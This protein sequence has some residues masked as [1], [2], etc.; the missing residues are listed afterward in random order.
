[1]KSLMKNN[2]A[3][4]DSFQ[5]RLYVTV[6]TEM[7]A[8][9]HWKKK[10]PP[11]FSSVIEGIPKILRPV[12]DAYNI[13]PI[14][15]VSP[16][17]VESGECCEVLK[18]EAAKGA[19]IGA[20]L[21]P[22]YIG[23]CRQR[24]AKDITEQFPCIGYSREI[25]KAKISSLSILI[26]ERLGVQ[27]EWYRAARFGTDADTIA[28]L[29]ELGFKYDSSFT[30]H[31]DWTKKG[32]P[33]HKPAPLH[34]YY[35]DC[36]HIYKDYGM[37]KGIKEYPVTIT[38]KR[39]GIL[40]KLLPDNWLFYQW[41]RP[42]HMFY[43]EQKH[44]I[45]EC[46][47]ADVKDIVMMFHSMEVMVGKTPYVR[48]KWMQKYY[49]WRLKKTIAFAQSQGYRGGVCGN[50]QRKGMGS[51]MDKWKERV[52]A[53]YMSNGFHSAHNRNKEFEMHGKYFKKNYLKFMP[54]DKKA[55]ILDLGCGMGQ[56]LYFCQ[57]EG[58]RNY[59]GI[60]ASKENIE[61]I[62]S[63]HFLKE[64]RV[65]RSSIIGFLADKKECYDVVV[66]NDVIEH[67]TKQEVFD[68]LDAVMASL[69][70][71]GVFLVKTPNMAN[72]FVNTAGR[73]IDIT[74]ETGFTETSMR[75]VLRA[76]G[77]KDIHITGTDIYVLNPMIS[78]A[79]KAVSKI[80]NF[81][82]RMMSALYGRTSIKI[83]EKDILAAAYK[84]E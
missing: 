79:A 37:K 36:A 16:E 11:Q 84:D 62:K 9:I 52:Y 44:I 61:F 48:T 31:I 78:L 25:E 55:R 5:G 71:G 38:G 15:F 75:Q 35:V 74:H 26:Q 64:G 49:I 80:F 24:M 77:F 50:H 60:D 68:V 21:H 2:P 33:N 70:K 23:P 81:F 59:A 18:K 39:F 58:Y 76:V 22:E 12:W 6:D 27:P 82:L 73:Y 1:M 65:C 19:V 57:K 32:G 66:L 29:Q 30:P 4:K 28:S 83:F 67:L 45:K 43:A 56:F 53:S 41:L 3:E 13:K 47:K 51:K 42:T 54:K 17:V 40:G 10:H 34:S 7:D 8:D 14:Y 72:P 46:R 69:K 20:H 63:S